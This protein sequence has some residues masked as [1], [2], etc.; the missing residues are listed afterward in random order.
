M[1]GGFFW[2]RFGHHRS[3]A[4]LA[5][6]ATR[7]PEWLDV[8]RRTHFALLEAEGFGIT[9]AN[10]D[11]QLRSPCRQGAACWVSRVNG[12]L[13][14]LDEDWAYRVI[15]QVGNYSKIHERNVGKDRHWNSY[16]ASARCGRAAG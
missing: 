9:Q 8:V 11:E 5:T 2:A 4:R 12:K 10:V 6:L 14:G 16:A 15:K 3:M 1:S 7:E 13:L